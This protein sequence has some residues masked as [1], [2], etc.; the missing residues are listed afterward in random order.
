MGLRRSVRAAGA[1]CG[2]RFILRVRLNLKAVDPPFSALLIQ[3]DGLG[4][5]LVAVPFRTGDID[6]ADFDRQEAAPTG[7][8]FQV[9]VCI[10]CTP[11]HAGARSLDDP[12]AVRRPEAV[13]GAADEC[14]DAGDLAARHRIE[15]RH[16]N[17]PDAARLHRRVLRAEVREFV[18][19]PRIEQRLDRR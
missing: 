8:I 7:L 13:H 3:R 6:L 14:L 10:G 11:E 12:A 16:L 15:L 1:P 2:F 19:E 17:P 18:G 9:A 4:P 5:E